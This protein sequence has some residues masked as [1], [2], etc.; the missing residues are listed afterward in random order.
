[1]SLC[2]MRPAGVAR[3]AQAANECYVGECFGRGV[4]R[5]A[6]RVEFF[7]SSAVQHDEEFLVSNVACTRGL[8]LMFPLRFDAA[9]SVA[10]SRLH[11]LG[12]GQV[13]GCFAGQAASLPAL[14]AAALD[15][16]RH[17]RAAA[18]GLEAE[19]QR[20]L[21]VTKQAPIES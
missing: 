12:P 8:D 9:A 5:P 3:P 21:S 17:R 4:G 14:H 6:A 2:E 10:T 19:G 13:D 16:Y 20:G 18:A 1:M 11:G 7:E 15:E